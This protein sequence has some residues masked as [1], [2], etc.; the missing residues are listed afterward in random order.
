MHKQK[1]STFYDWAKPSLDHIIPISRGGSDC[2]DNL[3]ILTVFEN[4][5]KRDL[6]MEEWNLF[7]KENKT[8]SNYFI[9]NIMNEEIEI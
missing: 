3:Q 1:N 5:S 9:E 4:F 6:T 8:T 2:L 7:K